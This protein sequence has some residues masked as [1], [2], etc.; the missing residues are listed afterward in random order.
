MSFPVEFYGGRRTSVC[1]IPIKKPEIR[2]LNFLLAA[3]H[4]EIELNPLAD[5]QIGEL[6]P[7]EVGHDP[8]LLERANGHQALADL[9]EVPGIYVAPGHHPVD[10]ADH[11]AILQIEF[12]EGQILLGLHQFG[13]GLLDEGPVGNELGIDVVDIPLGIELIELGDRL[14][15]GQIPGSWYVTEQ[16]RRLQQ[17]GE[18]FPDK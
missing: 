7:L 2:P 6:D 9:H 1:P 4:V 11:P 8:E 10:L 3:I 5:S 15:G 17:I 14:I 16:R 13:F 12:R 18:Q